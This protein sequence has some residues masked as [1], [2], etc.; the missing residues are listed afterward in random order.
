MQ[1]SLQRYRIRPGDPSTTA[2]E[3]SQITVLLEIPAQP[4]R[5]A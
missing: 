1:A 5:S 2:P 4:D 3:I